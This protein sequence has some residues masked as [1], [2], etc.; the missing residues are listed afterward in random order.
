MRLRVLGETVVDVG[1]INQDEMSMRE[2]MRQMRGRLWN[3]VVGSMTDIDH[4][5]DGV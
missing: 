3:E 1:L 2:M 4:Y 5:F